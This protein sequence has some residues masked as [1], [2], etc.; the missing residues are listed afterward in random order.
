[1]FHQNLIIAFKIFKVKAQIN[2]YNNRS[3]IKINNK[4][5]KK[6][7]IIMNNFR[8][9]INKIKLNNKTWKFRKNITKLK[10]SR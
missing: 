4:M 1:M 10:I 2:R 7:L 3:K 5:N 8:Y 6:S 9:H